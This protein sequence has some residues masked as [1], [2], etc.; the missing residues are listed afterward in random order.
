[1]CTDEGG[2]AVGPTAGLPFFK[3]YARGRTTTYEV[4]RTKVF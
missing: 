3:L 1:M 4:V 2:P